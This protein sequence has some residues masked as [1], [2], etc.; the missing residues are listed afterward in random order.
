M[1]KQGPTPLQEQR[2]ENIA[3]FLGRWVPRIS[4][5][6]GGEDELLKTE[7]DLEAFVS[8]LRA[9]KSPGSRGSAL[10]SVKIDRF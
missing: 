2:A 5:G 6:I 7:L 9:H 10:R 4:S 3:T 8:R 1:A